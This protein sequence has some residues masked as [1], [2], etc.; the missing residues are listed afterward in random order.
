M[1]LFTK[2]PKFQIFVSFQISRVNVKC[3]LQYPYKSP[4]LCV[5]SF[6]EM[7]TLNHK[8]AERGSDYYSCLLPYVLSIGLGIGCNFI[9]DNQLQPTNRLS[10]VIS[11]SHFCRNWVLEV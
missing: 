4:S 8:R 6:A 1:N 7:H 10:I 9:I 11:S 3:M 5:G 2:I